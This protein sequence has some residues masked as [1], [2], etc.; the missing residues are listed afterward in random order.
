MKQSEI[1]AA[2]QQTKPLIQETPAT[3][4]EKQAMASDQNQIQEIT[5]PP[6]I[7]TTSS[8]QNESLSQVQQLADTLKNLKL[9]SEEH[10]K[11]RELLEKG[12]QA[13]TH[14]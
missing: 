7:S 12:D 4:E 9:S 6:L 1:E 2:A 10:D 8:G 11:V 3:Q 14:E 13:D 5:N